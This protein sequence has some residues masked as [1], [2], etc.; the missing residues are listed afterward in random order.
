MIS[1]CIA[2]Y[3]GEK[4]IAEQLKSILPQLNAEDEVI[5]S[6]DGS[7]DHTQE[8]VLQFAA[9]DLRIKWRNGPGNGVIANYN[10]AISESR[11]DF[12]FLSD[13]DDVWLPNK[14]KETLAFFSAHPEKELVVSD[15]IVVDETLKPILL[16]YFDYR[17]VKTGF[18][19]NLWKSG[20]IG[21]GMCFRKSLKNIALPIPPTVP[22]HDMWLGLIS[23]YHGKSAFLDKE[24]TYYRRHEANASEIATSSSGIQKLRWRIQLAWALIKRLLLKR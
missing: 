2:A 10:F 15:L 12:I 7:S 6:D 5:I 17:K 16:S 24:L 1:V 21:A 18:L 22:M 20:Y 9:E 23:D 3:N 11:G 14:V 8:I 13:Q 19:S 4:Y